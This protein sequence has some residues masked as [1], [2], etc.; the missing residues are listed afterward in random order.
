[1]ELRRDETNDSVRYDG[2]TLRAQPEMKTIQSCRHLYEGVHGVRP[3]L[4]HF[5]SSEAGLGETQA[6]RDPEGCRRSAATRPQGSGAT[7]GFPIPIKLLPS[8][9]EGHRSGCWVPDGISLRNSIS[10]SGASNKPTEIP[11]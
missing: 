5:C 10:P 11:R 4:Y 2:V 6:V 9:F 1:M 7:L 8:I 3:S